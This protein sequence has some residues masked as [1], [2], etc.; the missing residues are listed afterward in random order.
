MGQDAT[1]T[2]S[3]IEAARQRLQHDVDLLEERVHPDDLRARARQVGIIA[4]A[5]GLGVVVVTGLVRR[6]LHHRA[7]EHHARVQ[8]QALAT[9]LDEVRRER[10]TP[11][12]ASRP[13]EPSPEE[14][15]SVVTLL[16]ALAALAATVIQVIGRRTAGR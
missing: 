14:V 11:E 8:A 15:T 6:R 2:L 16:A 7:E 1:A 5:S 12:R 9:A 13:D 4:A 10:D 3:E